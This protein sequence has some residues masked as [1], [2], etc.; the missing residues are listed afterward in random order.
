M[1]MHHMKPLLFLTLGLLSFI[2]ALGQSTFSKLYDLGV[3]W[4]NAPGDF[5]LWN[6]ELVVLSGHICFSDTNE[7]ATLAHF[8]REGELLEVNTIEAFWRGNE[9]S[10]LIEG[11]SVTLSAQENDNG[12]TSVYILKG[13]MPLTNY[14]VTE[15]LADDGFRYV[16]EGIFKYSG[17]CYTYGISFQTP[18]IAPAYANIIQWDS[19][20]THPQDNWHIL[21]EDNTNWCQD[22]QPTPDGHLAFFNEADAYEGPSSDYLV[23][24]NT[25]GQMVKSYPVDVPVATPNLLVSRDGS[26]Y[27]STRSHPMGI[28]TE[29][30][31]GRLNKLDPAM[32]E[33][34][35]SVELPYDVFTN[36]RNYDILDITETANG[37]LVVCGKVWDVDAIDSE[38][39]GFIARVTA[40]G[41]LLWTRLFKI[42]NGIEH[43]SLEDY[44]YRFSSL[45]KIKETEDGGLIAMGYTYRAEPG[46]IIYSE[47]W[48][49]AVDENGCLDPADCPEVRILEPHLDETSWVNPNHEWTRTFCDGFCQSIFTRRFRFADSLTAL[50]GH[51]WRQWLVSDE[52]FGDENFAPYA[53]GR[54]FRQDGQ[55]IY[56]WYKGESVLI[57]DFG[58]G[59]GDT[60]AVPDL[61][62]GWG[63]DRKLTVIQIDSVT[64]L[65]G[66]KRK[67]LRLECNNPWGFAHMIEGVGGDAVSL[68]VID[69]FCIAD[70]GEGGSLRCFQSHGE[71]LY[72]DDLADDCW[73]TTGLREIS[74]Q[75]LRVYPNP[76]GDRLFLD[77]AAP[78]KEV[79]LYDTQGR[80]V[81]AFT[82]VL[83]LD[84]SQVPTG[85]YQLLATD[86]DGQVY[87]ARFVVE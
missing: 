4:N 82:Q 34:E 81:A 52:E 22:L 76:A 24:L 23:K 44:Y 53:E 45:R 66:S 7:C 43:E 65:D 48:L 37:D 64:L 78:M 47:L 36:K 79:L 60:L 6:D 83:E 27:F 41:E 72:L 8:D 12:Q 15:Y 38:E 70:G 3:G 29:G 31:Y 40:Q 13:N 80:R 20:C 74:Y 25:Q 17:H 77:A 54:Y 19:T 49:L 58:L 35:W 26:F 59:V 61:Y 84:L 30:N 42:P 55:K 62:S 86:A 2:G 1:Y 56:Q 21:Q 28:I 10:M 5:A 63:P 39:H 68:F 57:M 32:E 11:D 75:S 71:H 85:L 67:R 46:F 69:E 73:V 51:L 33:L 87:V 16:N 9:Q 14:T 18:G 50:G